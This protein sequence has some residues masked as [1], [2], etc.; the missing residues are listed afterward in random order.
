MDCGTYGPTDGNCPAHVVHPDPRS[1]LAQFHSDAITVRGTL[2]IL[3]SSV[4]CVSAAVLW[5][6]RRMYGVR[7]IGRYCAGYI[8]SVPGVREA[9]SPLIL[10]LLMVGCHPI[11]TDPSGS[12]IPLPCLTPLPPG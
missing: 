8:R 3:E 4:D 1:V 6:P 7:Y 9:R 11:A 5:Y 10:A 12:T 2:I